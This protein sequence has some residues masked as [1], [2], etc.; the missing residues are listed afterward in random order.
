MRSCG[1]C[2]S[3][4][5]RTGSRD[6][7]RRGSAVRDPPPAHRTRSTRRAG[8]APARRSCH[9]AAR[10]RSPGPARSPR[11]DR[12][13]GGAGQRRRR[14]PSPE[15]RSTPRAMTTISA[16]ATTAARRA[17]PRSRRAT[18]VTTPPSRSTSAC[19]MGPRISG[20]L[21]APAIRIRVRGRPIT[22]TRRDP[23]RAQEADLGGAQRS[24]PPGRPERLAGAQ[25][26]SRHHDARALGHR[27]QH[28]DP[29]VALRLHGVARH[30]GIRPERQRLPGPDP[31]DHAARQCAVGRLCDRAGERIVGSGADRRF[32]PHGIAVLDGA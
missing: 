21:A 10:G 8:P 23:G 2:G 9:P 20:A 24:A 14:S 4:G 7:G 19:S 27:R 28:A 26:A 15:R 31:S 29:T 16:S 13:L 17:C 1:S 5:T 22:A 11:R 25:L 12:H 30:D 18:S 3:G 6:R 32:G